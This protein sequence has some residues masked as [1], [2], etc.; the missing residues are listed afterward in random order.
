ME[1]SVS[2]IQLPKNDHLTLKYFP[3]SD[4]IQND[5]C[6]FCTSKM[7]AFVK[8]LNKHGEPGLVTSICEKCGSVARTNNLSEN[9]MN[10]HFADDW[11]VNH[12]GEPSEDPTILNK[13]SLVKHKRRGK[14]LDVG[15]GNGS[16]LLAF[17]NA[18]YTTFGV[19]PSVIRSS[20]AMKC[21][22]ADIHNMTGEE[23][24]QYTDEKFDFIYLFDVLQFTHN[25]LEL[26]KLASTRLEDNGLVWWKFGKFFKRSNILQFGHY[27]VLRNYFNLYTIG[28]HL[29]ELG[30][31]LI[32]FSEEP[33]EIMLRKT[34]SSKHLSHSV[35][36]WTIKDMEKFSK[37]SI[38]YWKSKIL[39]TSTVSYLNRQFEIKLMKSDREFRCLRIF[40]Q[41]EDLP[42]LLK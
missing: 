28:F 1:I 30:L 17:K 26:L 42:L 36:K 37:K 23:Y 5:L 32:S 18:G 2:K 27:A 31:E 6:R 22:G 10:K 4:F 35:R 8:V 13:L 3:V 38:S 40:H 41:T 9:A 20:Q 7:H 25:P 21:I 14:I 34:K 11:L 15:C 39:G 33:F 12:A 24:L 19:E 29:E 16:Y